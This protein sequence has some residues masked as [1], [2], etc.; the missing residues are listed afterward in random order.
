M[1]GCNLVDQFLEPL[2][3]ALGDVIAAACRAGSRTLPAGHHE[4]VLLE[5]PEG[6]VHLAHVLRRADELAQLL[7]QI[8]TQLDL[9]PAVGQ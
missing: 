1:T 6:P 9:A 4:T 2:G 7:P 8:S 5:T 3:A